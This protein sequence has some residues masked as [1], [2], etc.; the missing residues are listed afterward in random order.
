MKNMA[1]FRLLAVSLAVGLCP[2]G[3]ESVDGALIT[4][5]TRATWSSAVSGTITT[6]NLNGIVADTE[7]RTAPLSVT[8]MT[9]QEVGGPAPGGS[10]VNFVD[11]SPFSGTD[12]NGS[13]YILGDVGGTNNTRIRIDFTSPVSAFGFDEAGLFV[14]STIMD[15]YDAF[16]VLIGTTAPQ[17]SGTFYG[18]ELDA[19]ESVGRVELRYAASGSDTFSMD[20]LS[21]V[22]FSGPL[23]PPPPAPSLVPEPSGL[24]L[25]G[26][27]A[28]TLFGY[29]RHKRR[30]AG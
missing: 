24:A 21:F 6:E 8:N 12:V 17:G 3:A 27:G 30:K 29:G 18:F 10:S 26:I 23:L 19:G 13:S 25:L 5:N 14:F 16:N 4:Y 22:S 15:V 28:L 2:P 7:F 9:I 20:D 1:R 11:A